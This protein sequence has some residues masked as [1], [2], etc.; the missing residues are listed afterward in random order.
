MSNNKISK[1]L[2]KQAQTSRRNFLQLCGKL[3]LSAGLAG[4]AG[5]N[6]LRAAPNG[7][8]ERVIFFYFPNGV[9]KDHYFPTGSGTNFTLNHSMQALD[10]FKS[11]LT[12]FNQMRFATSGD[13]DEGHTTGAMRL[14]TARNQ[15]NGISIDKLLA[16]E[17]GQGST[18]SHIHLGIQS[19]KNTNGQQDIMITRLDG[20]VEVGPEDNPA[21]A[22]R[23]LFADAKP[24]E[25]EEKQLAIIDSLHADLMEL[26]S[27]A[28]NDDANK[29]LQH[30]KA[31]EEIRKRTNAN[32]CSGFTISG[33]NEGDVN[34]DAAIPAITKHQI[35]NMVHAMACNLS[36]VGTIQLSHHTGEH[37]MNWDYLAGT[38]DQVSHAASHNDTNVHREQV[39][40]Y[41]EQ[42]AYLLGELQS[43]PDPIKPGNMLDNSMVVVLSEISEGPTHIKHPTP[44]F[45]AGGASGA[46]N[47]GRIIDCNNASHAN[48]LVSIANAMGHPMTSFG[49][50][51]TG[52]LSGLL[53]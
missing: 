35:D 37:V 12:M 52:P 43:R 15:G 21:A 53:V 41:M 42:V 28:G 8:C 45:I 40:W 27:L 34:N 4:F 51:G 24:I 22:N 38:N 46:I 17:I 48:M 26:Q 6:A 5:G 23:I 39:R 13:G 30:A 2:I 50:D 20:G 9:A 32:S 33:F 14:L 7:V 49:D 31:V 1:H 44:F 47:T 11:S 3:G 16:D 25:I 19:H 36:R 10:P 29:L 18:H